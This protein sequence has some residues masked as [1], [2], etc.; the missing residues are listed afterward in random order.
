MREKTRLGDVF[1]VSGAAG[2]A[3]RDRLR[4]FLGSPIKRPVR[5]GTRALLEPR[6]RVEPVDS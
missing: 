6:A 3:R 1:A 4:G 5:F 2:G